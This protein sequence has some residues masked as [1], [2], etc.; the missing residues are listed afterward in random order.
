ME[1]HAAEKK[2]PQRAVCAQGSAY[3]P[4]LS[5]LHW[6]Y[7]DPAS[8]WEVYAPLTTGLYFHDLV[9]DPGELAQGWDP[10][11]PEL[12]ELWELMKPDHARV[13]PI[14]QVVGFETLWPEG[15]PR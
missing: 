8:T 12:L 10:P 7:A 1:D 6:S 9:A 4:W 14:A 3:A 13:E 2:P 11:D 5:G 15:L